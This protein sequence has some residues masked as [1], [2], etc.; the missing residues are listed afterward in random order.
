MAVKGSRGVQRGRLDTDLG[1]P[2]GTGSA[3]AVIGGGPAGCAAALGLR[4]RAPEAQVLLFEY[5]RF[6]EHYNQCMGV[7]SPPFGRNLAQA[8]GLALPAGLVKGAVDTYVLHGDRRALAL[9]DEAGGEISQVVRRSELDGWLFGEVAE[10]GVEIR[11]ER[12]THLEFRSRDVVVYSDGGTYSVDCVVGAFGLD[13]TLRKTLREN[14]AYRPPV[15]VDTIVTVHPVTPGKD[16]FEE[17]AIHTFL[18]GIPNVEF[19]AVV[20]KGDH[21]GIVVAGRNVGVRLL[22]RVVEQPQVRAVLPEAF[23]LETAFRGGFP[24]RPAQPLCGDRW[25]VVGDASGLL[26]PFKGKGI[27]QAIRS[28]GLVARCLAENGIGRHAFGPL[29][30]EFHDLIADRPWGLAARLAVRAVGRTIGWDPVIAAASGDPVLR[31]ALF[32][33]VSGRSTFRSILGRLLGRRRLWQA[34]VSAALRFRPRT[35]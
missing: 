8:T 24:T 18:P 21:L 12:V 19:V 10:A 22:R 4:R 5:K 11:T 6:G 7:L 33:A 35:T 1:R 9:R 3:V 28:G 16:R 25:V 30:T 27:N 34:C 2:V 13:S 15:R 23:S 17:R 29:V 31:G 32:D 20:P 14:S 26:R